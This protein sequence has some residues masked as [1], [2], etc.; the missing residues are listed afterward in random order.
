MHKGDIT[1]QDNTM[2]EYRT[3]IDSCATNYAGGPPIIKRVQRGGLTTCGDCYGAFSWD[4]EPYTHIVSVNVPAGKR[5][6]HLHFR[7][8]GRQ[9][10]SANPPQHLK[11]DTVTVMKVGDTMPVGDIDLD[12]EVNFRDFAILADNWLVIQPTIP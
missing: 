11:I 3:A 8:G 4:W 1:G 9:D 5:Y 10:S 2:F 12:N 7:L 6:L